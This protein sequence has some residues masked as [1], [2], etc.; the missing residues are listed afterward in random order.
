[1]YIVYLFYLKFKRKITS[2]LRDLKIL[3]LLIVFNDL[4]GIKSSTI[5]L[6]YSPASNTLGMGT[7]DSLSCL[8]TLDVYVVQSPHLKQFVQINQP[9][10]FKVDCIF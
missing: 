1:M 7:S 3:F 9:K 6:K 10:T 5:F 4:K 2:I 8:C